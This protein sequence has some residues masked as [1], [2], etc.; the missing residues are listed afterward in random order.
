MHYQDNGIDF[1]YENGEYNLYEFIF[2]E[3]RSNGLKVK[4]LHEGFEGKY[5]DIKAVVC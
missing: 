3:K 1:A 2:S 4:M 5:Q